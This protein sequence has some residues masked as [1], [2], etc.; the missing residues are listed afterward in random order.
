MRAAS[1]PN[2]F[3][4]A[5]GARQIS[6]VFTDGSDTQAHTPLA[7]NHAAAHIATNVCASCRGCRRARLPELCHTLPPYSWKSRLGGRITWC[8]RARDLSVNEGEASGPSGSVGVNRLY[9]LGGPA[10]AFDNARQGRLKVSRIA[11]L[12][13]PFE[14]LPANLR[15]QALRRAFHDAK[16]R[17]ENDRGVICLTDT[18]QN[19][20]M[21]SHYGDKHRG[22]CLGFDV[23]KDL[24]IP[25][26]YRRDLQ[27]ITA[28][29]IPEGET[30][31]D[32]F[33][34]R[35][36]S[37]KFEDWRYEREQRIVVDLSTAISE[38]NLY[39]F[40]PSDGFLLREIILGARC[41]LAVAEARRIADAYPHTVYV[42]KARIAFTK[43]RVVE[44]KRY[45]RAAPI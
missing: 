21:W 24:T 23:A 33:V 3:R 27:K 34:R 31:T 16:R 29:D 26:T 6:S 11:N 36:L 39:F 17:V 40:R 22:V 44:D 4:P 43:F 38:G 7:K 15:D 20:V 5:V 41:D 10:H 1:R 28:A 37:V 14:L 13:D 18:W 35:F 9:N 2:T 30:A 12:N 19:P 42:T 8:A 25:V 45:R 32:V